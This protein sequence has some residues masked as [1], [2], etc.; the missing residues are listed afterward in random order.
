MQNCRDHIDIGLGRDAMSKLN[1]YCALPSLVAQR[2]ATG[3]WE[4]C[5]HQDYKP[6][7]INIKRDKAIAES[8][9]VRGWCP[10]EKS[11]QIYDS[12]LELVSKFGDPICIELGVYAGKSLV[13]AAAALR[14]AGRGIITGIDPWDVEQ[15]IEGLA[16]DG[17]QGKHKQAWSKPDN[18]RE[19]EEVFTEAQRVTHG[20]PVEL[21]KGLPDSFASEYDKIHYLHIDDNH[22]PTVSVRN[23]LTWMPKLVSGGVLVLDDAGWDSVQDARRLIQAQCRILKSDNSE[24]HRWEVYEKL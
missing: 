15:G 9:A 12:V 13:A 14:D 8:Q 6:P 19:Y 20:M 21:R 11:G 3:E 4:G 22:S 2:T 18:V 17:E 7:V 16:D 5:C 1:W 24:G 23:V 10:L